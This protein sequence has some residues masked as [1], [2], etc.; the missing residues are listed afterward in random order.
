M[1]LAA[2]KGDKMESLEILSSFQRRQKRRLKR[3]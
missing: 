1:V 3:E 2:Q